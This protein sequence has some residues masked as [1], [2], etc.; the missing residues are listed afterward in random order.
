MRYGY[1]IL[2]VCRMLHLKWRETKQQPS[3]ARSDF[4]CDTLRTP[5]VLSKI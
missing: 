2:G 4:L 1:C 3:R 5:V